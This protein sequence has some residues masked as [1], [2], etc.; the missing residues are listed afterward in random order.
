[1]ADLKATNENVIRNPAKVKTADQ[2]INWVGGMEADLAK[3]RRINGLDPGMCGV[4]IDCG[5]Y[6][7]DDC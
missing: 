6:D 5:D 2:L 4:D 7:D 1:M 3:Y